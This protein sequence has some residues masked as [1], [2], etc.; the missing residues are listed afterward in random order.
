[1]K[2]VAAIVLV[3]LFLFSNSFSNSSLP[4]CKGKDYSNW[5]NCY[6]EFTDQYDEKFKYTY[7]GEFGKVPGKWEGLGIY[8][9]IDKNG[10]E[11]VRYEGQVSN[12]R[13]F[14]FGVYTESDGLKQIT[15]K[16]KN[17]IGFSKTYYPEGDIYIGQTKRGTR[18]GKGVQTTKGKKKI[19]IYAMFENDQ[20]TTNIPIEQVADFEEEV[21]VFEAR[22]KAL[23]ECKSYGIKITSNEFNKCSE[24][25]LK[26]YT[27]E[28]NDER[29]AKISKFNAKSMKGKTQLFKD[30]DG[31]LS[32]CISYTSTG[33]CAHKIPYV[34][35]TKKYANNK[36]DANKLIE[37]G[38]ILLGGTN[39]TYNNSEAR[40][41][42]DSMS[43]KMLECAGQVTNGKCFNFKPY[44]MNS[45]TYDTLFFNPQTG[46]MQ[47][48]AQQV[49]GKCN[50]FRPQPSLVNKDQLFYDSR[51]R[52]MR[53]CLNSTMQGK[54]LAFGMSP[55]HR[56]LNQNTG[57]Y[58]VDSPI[59]PYFKKVPR[60][61]TQLMTLGLNMLSGGCTLGLNC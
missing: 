15:Q 42:Y 17:G 25:Q 51:T 35:K 10:K 54:C 61:N 28:L 57:T 27:K 58:I 29:L 52:S 21:L 19:E 37:L 5:T 30:E 11:V 46:S 44:N 53:T 24:K 22:L 6:G 59:N 55:S 38:I 49:L 18:H 8:F 33:A 23:E 47:K 16:D 26:F 13:E 48:C 7:K 1:M 14:G 39:D 9:L 40:L 50:S 12:G 4:N 36:F 3:S 60:T 41:F 34:I 20:L 43:G 2:I 45:Y 32:E 31:D 56:N